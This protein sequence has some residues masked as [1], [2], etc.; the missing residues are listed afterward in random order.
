M[1]YKLEVHRVYTDLTQ[2]W[3]IGF[4]RNIFLRDYWKYVD[5]DTDALTKQNSQ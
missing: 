2:P 5:I 1:P 4:N 3:V